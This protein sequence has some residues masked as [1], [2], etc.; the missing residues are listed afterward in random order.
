MAEG[1][2]ATLYHL[3]DICRENRDSYEVTEPPK[4]GSIPK[5]SDAPSWT[6]QA[7]VTTNPSSTLSAAQRLRSMIHFVLVRLERQKADILVHINVPYAE[8]ERS[9]DPNALPR[10]EGFALEVLNRMKQTLEILDYGLFG[11]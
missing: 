3:G 4:H 8:L 6:C 11:T 9:G 1:E 10:E 7:L 2:K 5:I